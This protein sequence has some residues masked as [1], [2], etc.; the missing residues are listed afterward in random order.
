MTGIFLT[1]IKWLLR[2]PWTFLLM[3]VF[4]IG[5]AFI[6]GGF[7]SFDK[8]KVP[9]YV[10]EKSMQEMDVVQLIEK[11]G[12]FVFEW[13]SYEEMEEKII[14]G[15]SEF[16]L[17]LY[18]DDFQIIVGIDSPNIN[19]VEQ[20][21]TNAYRKDRQIDQLA[22]GILESKQAILH[23]ITEEPIF[24]T[25][26]TSFYGN[27]TFVYD[28]NLHSVYGF[29]LF[30][31]VY[32]IAY[33]VFQILIEKRSGVWDRMILSPI[34]KWEMYVANFLYSFLIGYSQILAVF[35]V[36]RFIIKVDFHGTFLQALLVMI[37]Y[38]L[39]IVALSILITG[40]V[41]TTQQYNA[42]IPIV[43][44]S[45]AMIGGAF[46]P[47]EIVESKFMLLLSKIV[48]ITYGMEALNGVTLYGY[49]FEQTLFPISILLLMSVIM[50]G[51]GIHLMEKRFIS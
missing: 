44:I 47:L 23:E 45:M 42:V 32:T 41:R 31:V 26:S 20:S 1:K 25:E 16:G 22:S 35:L 30:F 5:F 17:H 21:V 46:W 18:E 15:K 6:V 39:A 49:S 8:I 28:S 51:V 12:I 2:N 13:M 34:R 27:D 40:A 36:F 29:T 48:P 3:T 50:T 37:P 19:I 14:S 24:K 10:E 38:V 33:S 43:T 11:Q 9:T 7:N 4:S